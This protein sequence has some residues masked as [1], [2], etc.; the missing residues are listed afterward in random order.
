M[1]LLR[2]VMHNKYALDVGPVSLRGKK[3]KKTKHLQ[4]EHGENDAD[5]Q[6]SHSLVSSHRTHFLLQYITIPQP[7]TCYK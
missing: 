5:R 6:A 4:E 1:D 3:G 7:V 2:R